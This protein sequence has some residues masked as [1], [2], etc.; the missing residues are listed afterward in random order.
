M[1]R[2]LVSVSLY[3]SP[4]IRVSLCQ[5][6]VACAALDSSL[7]CFFYSYPEEDAGRPFLIEKEVDGAIPNLASTHFLIPEI[8]SLR[9]HYKVY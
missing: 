4:L 5:V 3:I 8:T 2:P 1:K 6:L 9:F 7:N